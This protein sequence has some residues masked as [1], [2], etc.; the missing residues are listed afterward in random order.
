[1]PS[2]KKPNNDLPRA[3]IIGKVGSPFGVK[4]W[5]KITSY[6][7]P[8]ENILS[9]DPWLIGDHTGHWRQNVQIEKQRQGEYLL[10]RF[11]NCTDRDLARQYTGLNIAITHD[12]LPK[13]SEG[14]YY[15]TDLEGLTVQSLT[16][17]ELG[18]IDHLFETSAND[19][20]VVLGETKQL[21][22]FIDQYIIKV[23][24]EN[25]LMIVDWEIVED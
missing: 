6:A 2:Q 21:I 18:K 11:E 8:P 19:V 25:S 14:E 17:K 13:A 20:V 23:D 4:G 22:P 9:Y 5:L 24:L 10:A 7:E 3:V 16:G 12:Q 1:M 15:W